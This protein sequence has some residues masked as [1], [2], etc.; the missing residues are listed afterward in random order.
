MC[1]GLGFGSFPK[2]RF[3]FGGPCNEDYS[4]LGSM[5]RSSHFGKLPFRVRLSFLA[6]P[7]KVLDEDLAKSSA[8]KWLG[9][10][11]MSYSLD[12]LKGVI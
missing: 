5:L 2:K 12:S 10:S 7:Y 6:R 11:Y 9:T 4:A 1:S 3:H 8:S